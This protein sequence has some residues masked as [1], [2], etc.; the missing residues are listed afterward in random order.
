MFSIQHFIWMAICTITIVIICLILKK[1]RPPLKNVLI[2]SFIVA[3]LSQLFIVITEIELVP[4]ADGETLRLFLPH[5]SLPLHMC[6]IQIFL[7]GAAIFLKRQPFRENLLAFIY[8]TGIGGAFMAIV[9]STI[10][11]SV[12]PEKSFAYPRAYE[13]FIYHCMLIILGVYIFISGEVKFKPKHILTTFIG[14]FALAWASIYYNSILSVPTYENGKLISV[15]YNTNFF[16][17]Y[18]PPIDIAL[19]ERWHWYVYLLILLA[20]VLILELIL[21]VPAI[22]YENKKRK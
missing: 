20:L 13:Y 11:N 14:L 15:D 10:F 22:I 16:F 12:S 19:T 9:V 8:A 17:T 21:F 4:S 7:I 3:A 18:E 1:H 5:S 2:G 6:S